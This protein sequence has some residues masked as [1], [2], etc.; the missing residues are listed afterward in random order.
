MTG[1]DWTLTEAEGPIVATAI[2]AGHALSPSA[3]RICALDEATRLREEDPFT[4]RWLSIA[5]TRLA[6]HLSRFELDLN[7]P[8]E[9]AVYLTP[10]QAWG[11]EVWREPLP[12][13]LLER[14]LARHAAFYAQLGAFLDRLADR[15]ER[16]AVFDLHSYC[17]RRAGPDA[18]PADPRANPEINLGTESV[19]AELRPLVER[20]AAE[21]RSF[22]FEGRSLDVRENV[23]FKGGH[24]PRWINQRYGSRV[25]AIAVELKKTF[26]DEW[27][28]QPDLSRIDAIG[29]ALDAAAVGVEQELADR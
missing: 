19:A 20:F 1:Q 2:H 5:P 7:R 9:T 6:V 8:P 28:G 13:E 14:C 12:Q 3:A 26:M 29:R 16:I 11:L 23:R 17:H 21:L 25:C 4:D 27:T 10:D 15:H 22:D 24:F 18:D